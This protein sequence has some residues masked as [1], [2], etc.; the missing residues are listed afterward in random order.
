MIL[1]GLSSPS[2]LIPVEKRLRPCGV[3][4]H[5]IRYQL[6]VHGWSLESVRSSLNLSSGF[7]TQVVFGH[8]RSARVEAEIARILGKPSWNDVVAEA[9]KATG[10]DAPPQAR[11]AKRRAV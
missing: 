9:R 2:K 8:R 1:T 3:E 6:A 7:I 10:G 11:D 5:Y 4:G